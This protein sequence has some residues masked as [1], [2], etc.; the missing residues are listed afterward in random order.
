MSN[1]PQ[2]SDGQSILA[3][4]PSAYGS[5]CFH[6][7]G[8]IVSSAICVEVGPTWRR[9]VCVQDAADQG[10]PRWP[11]GEE[12]ARAEAVEASRGQDSRAECCRTGEL[13]A[14][15]PFWGNFR[16][17]GEGLDFSELHGSSCVEKEKQ[18]QTDTR[19]LFTGP[20]APLHSPSNPFP[21]GLP[22]EHQI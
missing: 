12:S 16:N 14:Q 17:T 13:T 7:C 22:S 18:A 20:W 1:S 4:V 19:T 21:T 6:F 15:S 3:P 5:G 2:G 8:I 11:G 10:D 9:R